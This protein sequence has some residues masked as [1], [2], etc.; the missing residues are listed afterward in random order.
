MVARHVG[1]F[2]GVGAAA[3]GDVGS[4]IFFIRISSSVPDQR[5]MPASV[6]RRISRVIRLCRTSMSGNG[7][8]PARGA[9]QLDGEL[10]GHMDHLQQH[11]LALFELS[12]IIHQ[13][14]GQVWYSADQS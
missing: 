3:N 4:C 11:F 13:E 9:H 5:G 8:G 1:V 12:G 7:S 14:R 6:P 10:V 2:G